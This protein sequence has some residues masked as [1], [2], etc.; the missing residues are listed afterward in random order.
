MPL[1]QRALWALYH[2]GMEHT[3]SLCVCVCVCLS[4]EII[5]FLPHKL[6]EA[7]TEKR[8]DVFPFDF[9][10]GAHLSTLSLSCYHSHTQLSQ[11]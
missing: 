8:M 10:F 3:P 9:P 4:G 6:N 7:P 2:E 5:H 11:T 1:T